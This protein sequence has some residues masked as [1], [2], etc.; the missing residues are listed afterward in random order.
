MLYCMNNLN[1][2]AAAIFAV[3][4][5]FFDLNTWDKQASQASKLRSGMNLLV[6]TTSPDNRLQF[7]EWHYTHSVFRPD[8]QGRSVQVMCGRRTGS[9]EVLGR[10]EADAKHP[11]VFRTN[12]GRRELK[13]GWSVVGKPD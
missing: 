4:E 5:A 8:P 13:L 1:R 9:V 7:E 2:D 3:P 12:R 11:D 6:L 10:E